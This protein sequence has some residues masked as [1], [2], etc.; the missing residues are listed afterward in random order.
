MKHIFFMRLL[1]SPNSG[2][3][4][5]VKEIEKAFPHLEGGTVSFFF[6]VSNSDLIPIVHTRSDDFSD[7]S[8]SLSLT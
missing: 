3:I 5:Q 4:L 7:T 6:K 2:Y 8:K 1:L